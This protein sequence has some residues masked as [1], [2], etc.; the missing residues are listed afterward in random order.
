MLGVGRVE[1]AVHQDRVYTMSAVSL[2]FGYRR[3]CS[4]RSDAF[5]LR[6]HSAC[7][8]GFFRWPTSRQ[9]WKPRPG[10]KRGSSP[11]Q[12]GQTHR[13]GRDGDNTVSHRGAELRTRCGDNVPDQ[14]VGLSVGIAE[15]RGAQPDATLQTLAGVINQIRAL[16][17]TLST[18]VLANKTPMAH[19]NV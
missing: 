12:I 18:T 14:N 17:S 8:V 6:P 19:S 10:S 16:T 13:S 2:Q 5:P 1:T 15:S 4:T 11:Q 3:V 9:G 7:G